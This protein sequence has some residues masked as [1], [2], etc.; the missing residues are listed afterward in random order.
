MKLTVNELVKLLA[1]QDTILIQ[2]V[3]DRLVRHSVASAETL[4]FAIS[5]SLR[6]MDHE[7]GVQQDG[8]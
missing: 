1:E 3:A 7:M 6:D 5:C 8:V 2:E 4:E